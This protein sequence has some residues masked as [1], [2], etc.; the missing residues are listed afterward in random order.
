M[1]HLF[2]VVAGLV[3]ILLGVATLGG[4]A[5][6]AVS[7][8]R[9]QASRLIAIGDMAFGVALLVYGLLYHRLWALLVSAVAFAI[10]VICV[11]TWMIKAFA[12]R[13]DDEFGPA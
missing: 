1:G 7:H 13:A 10:G 12:R 8:S 5:G 3:L 6:R 2:E 11:I 4:R 9:W